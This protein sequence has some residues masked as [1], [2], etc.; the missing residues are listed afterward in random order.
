MN[1]NA[2]LA[3]VLYCMSL[4]LKGGGAKAKK[5]WTTGYI[6]WLESILDVID[7][8]SALLKADRDITKDDIMPIVE[9][10]NS[11]SER[12]FGGAKIGTEIIC[13]ESGELILHNNSGWDSLDEKII[14]C[15]QSITSECRRLLKD[16]GSGYKDRV[17][18][19]LTEFHNLPRAY[20]SRACDPE[21]K[22]TLLGKD[23]SR[24]AISKS[25]ALEYVCPP[26]L[27]PNRSKN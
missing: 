13:D 18:K 24:S 14:S 4:R 8:S 26:T 17:Q 2:V 7:I 21:G 1:K 19:L 3:E 9:F 25:E 10:V 16:R 11:N 23:Y 6:N 15:M 12:L 20:L 5:I 27:S 22:S